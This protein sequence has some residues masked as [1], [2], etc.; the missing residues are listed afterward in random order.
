MAGNCSTCSSES[1]HPQ[2]QRKDQGIEFPAG[3]VFSA[4]PGIV[5]VQDVS[6]ESKVQLSQKGHAMANEIQNR[7][8]CTLRGTTGD[9]WLGIPR[10]GGTLVGGGPPGAS[11]F[12]VEKQGDGKPLMSGDYVRIRGTAGDPWLRVPHGGGVVTGGPPGEASTFFI[13]KLGGSDG[14]EVRVGDYFKIRGTDGDPWLHVPDGPGGGI[15]TGGSPGNASVFVIDAS[16]VPAK[17]V[18]R[19]QTRIRDLGGAPGRRT[20]ELGWTVAPWP[21]SKIEW[22]TLPSLRLA[23]QRWFAYADIEAPNLGAAP[24]AILRDCLTA[25][26][27][28]CGLAAIVASPASCT[29]VFLGTF[30]GCIETKVAG[31]LVNAVQLRVEARCMW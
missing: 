21:C 30:K 13:E 27:A 24:E 7:S 9:P 28:A 4:S 3:R 11:V 14:P 19:A 2:V 5:R 17:I 25:A 8:Y 26:V 16:D 31:L 22:N 29:G 23:E 1:T 18:E 6:C 15:V 20:V 10:G 12:F